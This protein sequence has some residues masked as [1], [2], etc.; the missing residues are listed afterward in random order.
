MSSILSP[1]QQDTRTLITLTSVENKPKVRRK[2]SASPN[3]DISQKS[4]PQRYHV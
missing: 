4:K 3:T 1:L 2:A